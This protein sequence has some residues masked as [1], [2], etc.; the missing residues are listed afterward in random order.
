MTDIPTEILQEVFKQ[1]LALPLRAQSRKLDLPS[2]FP[3]YIGH[4]CSRWRSLFLS[5]R[6]TF[7]NR[8]EIELWHDNYSGQ[9]ESPKSEIVA[10]FLDC[11]RGAPFSFSFQSVRRDGCLKQDPY[12]IPLAILMHLLVHSD[13]WNEVSFQLL[14]SEVGCLSA[15]KGRLQLLKELEI[16][17]IKDNHQGIQSMATNIFEDAP[18]LTHITLCDDS[19]RRFKFNGSLLTIVILKSLTHHKNIHAILKV[20]Q[21]I[22]LV[23]LH[24]VETY[25]DDLHIEG[26]ELIHLPCLE[27]L[28]VGGVQ[29]LTVLETPTLRHLV[30]DLWQDDNS[31]SSRLANLH[32]AHIIIA[33]L[34]RL[35]IKLTTLRI[36]GGCAT[37]VEE[38]LLLMPE[39]DMLCL[40]SR[41]DLA[42]VF[43]QL[44]G[45]GMPELP[46]TNLFL[47]WPFYM[48]GQMWTH[49][50][51]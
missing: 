38:I 5:M 12:N 17:I 27:L 49:C 39:V 43:K 34:R 11:T 1:S 42:D 16:T 25:M 35:G 30:I 7:W 29:L 2:R 47:I 8:I 14:S 24:I 31:D 50:T 15:A 51:I 33:F 6:S 28:D 23:E 41:G 40:G 32:D 22:N 10:F 4:V 13:Q 18:L 46:F 21:A 26:G 48:T 19:V 9:E 44:A 20:I 3:W 36:Y 45:V 37:P